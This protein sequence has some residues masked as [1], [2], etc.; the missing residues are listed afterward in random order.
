MWIESTNVTDDGRPVTRRIKLPE[1]DEPVEFTDNGKAQVDAETGELLV[2]EVD[3]IVESGSEAPDD[4]E[5]ESDT[6]TED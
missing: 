1:L 3:S 2:R 5:T 6:E 4:D